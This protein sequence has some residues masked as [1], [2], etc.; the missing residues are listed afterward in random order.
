VLDASTAGFA[1]AVAAARQSD[2]VIVVVGDRSGLIDGCTSGE[3]VDRAG[4]GLPGV[5]QA[6]VEAIVATGK[7]V[8]VVLVNGRPLAVPWIA[9]NVPAILEA[10]LPGEEG[11]TAV[12]DVLF[13]DYNPGGRLPISVP[14]TVGQ[15]PVYYNHKPSGGRSN[16]KGDYVEATS[17]PLFPFG[18]GLSFTRFDYANLRITPLHVGASGRVQ[19][20][21]EVTNIG[22]RAGEEVVQLYVN[23]IVASVTRPVKELKGFERIALG[24]GERKN[25]T[26]DLP[27]SA[28]GFYDRELR[29]IVEPGTIAVMVGSSSEDIR[30]TGQFEIIGA[31][32]AIG[33]V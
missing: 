19:I 12:A 7:P 29:L 9:E 13:G 11:G 20:E 26:F 23:D 14:A 27:V 21:V 3:S 10:W 24:V 31:T 22:H 6:L 18:H 30:V 33:R 25:V 16:W 32:T 2:V 28:L 17:R 8:V 5:Q 4:L 1:G 15:V